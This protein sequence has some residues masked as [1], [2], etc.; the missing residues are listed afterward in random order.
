MSDLF[1]KLFGGRY[2]GEAHLPENGQR[3]DDNLI[4]SRYL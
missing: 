4:S 3:L 2:L 1:A